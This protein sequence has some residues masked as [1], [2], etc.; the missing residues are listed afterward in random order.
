[1]KSSLAL[2]LYQQYILIIINIRYDRHRPLSD[3][4]QSAL[5]RMLCQ[6]IQTEEAISCHRRA[7]DELCATLPSSSKVEKFLRNV[8][9]GFIQQLASENK[10]ESALEVFDDV[11]ISLAK[12]SS[13]SLLAP[14]STLSSSSSSSS[15]STALEVLPSLTAKVGA[16]L[17][18]MYTSAIR[19]TVGTV[20]SLQQAQRIMDHQRVHGVTPMWSC[21]R[22]A[23]F[24]SNE[25][26]T[27]MYS[28]IRVYKHLLVRAR[29][30]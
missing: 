9:H 15:S 20:R 8:S 14:P 26:V 18:M 6:C 2:K 19:Y 24:M 28:T 10:G 11:H 5:L 4:T 23:P 29:S 30:N 1:M 25:V 12:Y 16:S 17:P 3:A 27:F 13:L 7:L 21:T 22:Y